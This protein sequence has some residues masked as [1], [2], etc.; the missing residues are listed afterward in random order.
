MFKS[1]VRRQLRKQDT[2]AADLLSDP[3][4]D[5]VQVFE[6]ELLAFD[7]AICEEIVKQGGIRPT[8]WSWYE[9]ARDTDTP[10]HEIGQPTNDK[11]ET[12]RKSA[13]RTL[14][15]IKLELARRGHDVSGI[16]FRRR[17]RD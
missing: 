3:N 1:A 8:N 10:W 7:L 5:P 17:R 15:K 14:A 13:R 12:V 2:D 16:R 11:P 9:A 4:G 6:A